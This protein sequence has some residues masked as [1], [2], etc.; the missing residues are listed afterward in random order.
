MTK[1][2]VLFHSG[3]GHTRKQAEA[4]LE[5]AASVAPA[6]LMP[7]DSEGHISDDDWAATL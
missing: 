2:V 1:I 3:Y 6:H 4:V 5:G 7:I